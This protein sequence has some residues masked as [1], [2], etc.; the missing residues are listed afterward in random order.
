VVEQV[1]ERRGAQAVERAIGVI[2]CFGTD[3]PELSLRELARRAGLPVS[4]THR[5]TQALVRGGLLERSGRDR[6]RV[7]QRLAALAGPVLSRLGVDEAAPSLHKLAEGLRLTASVGVPGEGELLTVFSVRPSR[8]FHAAQVPSPHEPLH[9]SAMGKA[10]LA[11]TPGDTRATVDRLGPLHPFTGHTH[12]SPAALV[13]DL[14][15]VRRR[16]FA[17]SDSER[18][19]GVRGLA[20]PLFGAGHQVWGALGVQERSARLADERVGPVASVLRHIGAEIGPRVRLP[21]TSHS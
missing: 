17:V 11:F 4:T 2:D 14:D 5:I 6:Y 1:G 20:V 15:Q 18:T 9:A 8:D 7:G 19:E 21:A 13:A 16:G 3:E 10:V 12:T